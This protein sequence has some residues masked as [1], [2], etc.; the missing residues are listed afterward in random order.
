MVGKELDEGINLVKEIYD[1]MYF[2]SNH[3]CPTTTQLRAIYKH[4]ILLNFKIY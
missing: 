4:Q 2:Q 3:I 1:E